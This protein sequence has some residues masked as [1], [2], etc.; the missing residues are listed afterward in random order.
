MT[1]SLLSD[2]GRAWK[3]SLLGALLIGLCALYGWRATERPVGW[4]KCLADPEA[5]DGDRVVL[6]LYTVD[7]LDEAGHMRVSK[8]ARDVPVDLSELEDARPPEAGQ[9]VSVVGHF[10]ASDKVLVAQELEVHLLRWAKVAL[11]WVGL[12]ILAFGIP[13]SFRYRNGRLEEKWRTW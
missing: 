8:V 4:M 10:R 9:T 6:S 13:L 11:G 2:S 3:L 5:S 1:R 12:A 7:G